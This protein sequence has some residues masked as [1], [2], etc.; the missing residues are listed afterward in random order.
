MY[1]DDTN[2]TLEEAVEE[3]RVFVYNKSNPKGEILITFVQPSSG[4]SF[5]AHIPKTWIPVAL[6]DKVPLIVI[7]DSID[8]R[9][10]IQSKMLVLVPRVDAEKILNTQDA[11]EEQQRI[12]Q[13][14]FADRT[15]DEHVKQQKAL[16]SNVKTFIQEEN[17]IVK[18]ILARSDK[19][20]VVLNEL[21]AIEDE[22]SNSDLMYII[23]NSEGKVRAWAEKKQSV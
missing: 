18:D 13:S 16:D 19:V 12:Y 5:C 20:S 14:K 4:K 15:S 7:R 8:L 9:S 21:R 2:I 17:L 23:K 10:Y 6:S 22:L 11:K 3:G 1:D